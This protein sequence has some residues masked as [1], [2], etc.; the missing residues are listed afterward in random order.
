MRRSSL[1]LLVLVLAGCILL[2]LPALPASGQ[3]LGELAKQRIAQE[4]GLDEDLLATMFISE[5]N[6]QFILT[7]IYIDERTFESK[8]RAD[9]KA[10]IEPYRGREAMLVLITPA[11]ESYFNPLLISFT[12][13]RVT[14]KVKW[15]SIRR[16]SESFG[17]GT[18][19][20]GEVSAGVILLGEL[21]PELGAGVELG[22]LGGGQ[23]LD[24]RRPFTIN[25]MERYHA[26]F[27]LRSSGEP[28]ELGLSG[29]GGLLELLL[30]Q[31]L[32]LLLFFLLAFLLYG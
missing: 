11:R 14:Y 9:L 30:I 21:E 22:L 1:G 4:T 12:Q 19:P 10:A 17:P 8:L 29:E 31:L 20:A 28:L 27:S 26:D 24:A 7:F 3:D 15:T 6:A 18:L 13:D 23:R 16:I 2:V 25:Y 32:N 5:A